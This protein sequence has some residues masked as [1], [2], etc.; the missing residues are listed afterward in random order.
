VSSVGWTIVGD[1]R[2][3][4]TAL[5]ADDSLPDSDTYLR[6]AHLWTMLKARLHGRADRPRNRKAKYWG[7]T[8]YSEPP[9]CGCRQ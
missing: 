5:T 7:G 2:T 6:S 1:A 3:G 8:Y 4:I 9:F